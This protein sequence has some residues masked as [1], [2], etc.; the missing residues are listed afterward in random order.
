MLTSG[1]RSTLL[2]LARR[3][4]AA[5]AAGELLPEIRATGALAEHG[6]AFVTLRC[7]G[8]LRGCIGH[9]QAVEPLWLSVRNMARSAAVQDPRFSALT[10]AEVDELTLEISVLAPLREIQG[11]QDIE[12]G[13]DGLYIT[14]GLQAGLLLPQ[15]AV[16][17]GWD[18][19]RFL[20]HTC[21]KAGLPTGAGREPKTTLYAFAAE[22]FGEE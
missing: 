14:R 12:I 18:A 22:I 11:E 21:A 4:V 17:A 8:E 7:H 1:E 10:P 3:S 19:R 20:E 13:H 9:V 5:A 15:V 2:D 16:S 6:A